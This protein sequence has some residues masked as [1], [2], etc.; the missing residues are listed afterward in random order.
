MIIGN[1]LRALTWVTVALLLVPQSDLFAK[2]N[3]KAAEKISKLAHEAEARRDYDKALEYYKQAL[4]LEPGNPSYDMGMRRVRF[5]AGEVHVKAGQALREQGKVEESLAEFQRAFTIDPS[6]PIAL[7]E[8]RRTMEMVERNKKGNLPPQ[9]QTLTPAELE[10]HQAEE[11]I[12]SLES[13]PQLKPITGQ[14]STLKMNNQ[15]PKVL[16]ETVGKLAGINVVF[17]PQFQSAGKNV[18]LD[19]TNATLQEALDYVGMLTK[20][21]WKP[22]S[23]NTIFVA[24]DNVTKRRDY[25]DEVVKI[26]YL[27]NITSVQEF[28]E[29]VTAVRSVTDIRRCFTYGAQSA[30]MCRGTVDQVA[31]A[32]KLFHDL[33]KPKSEVLVDVIVMEVDRDVV[34]NLSAG[35]T[36]G[37]TTGLVLPIAFTPRNPVTTTTTT[38]STG[39]STTGTATTTTGLPTTTTGT[40]NTGGSSISLSQ[41]GKVS[42]SDFSLSLPGA[43]LEAIAT[44]NSSKVLQSPQV[45]ASD[46]QKV[47]LKIGD[48]VPYATGS[49]QPGIGTVGVSPLVSTQFQ[50][51]ETGVNIDITPHVHGS[52]ELTLHVIVDISSVSRTVTIGGLDQPVISQ[53]KNEAEVRLRD[54]EVSLLGGLMQ[55]QN[56]NASTGIP[57]IV[58]IPVL[59][60]LFFGS[61]NKE[62]VKQELLIALI[63]HIIRSPSITALDMAQVYAGQDQVPRVRFAPQST[64][65]PVAAPAQTPQPQ[66]PAPTPAAPVTP[67]A[68]APAPAVPT[69]AVPGAPAIPPGI[70]VLTLGPASAQVALS[71]PL[72]VAVEAHNM[73]DLFAAPFHIKWDPKQL[74]LDQ[75]T[76]GA[77]IGDGGPQANPPSVDIR[78][79][80]GE[81]S[82]TVSRVTGAPGVNGSGELAKL[83]FVAVGKGAGTITVNHAGLLNSKQEPIPTPGL[84]MPVTVQ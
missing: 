1:S 59:G 38:P 57:G 52:E 30:V 53:R 15:P 55:D 80:T 56:T 54:G 3:H 16:Y 41:I 23:A 37:G 22:I 76:P 69:A 25:E 48:K 36:S 5:E 78:N 49:F 43:L 68:P 32:E 45:R 79:E 2:N 7:Q 20:T 42:F 17:D 29:I 18:N 19:L 71:A 66:A 24:E 39:T 64:A 70:P 27:R 26:F 14:I 81:A 67:P 4:N 84:S 82:I 34:R 44:D 62:V 63:P 75:V 58:N 47:T 72:V 51:A 12:A 83:K 13:V 9:A 8:L 60:H 40:T 35:L 61:S 73:T 65:A 10:R 28:Q 50:F 21:F 77:F 46:G 74:R 6:S 33:D 31:L 11:R